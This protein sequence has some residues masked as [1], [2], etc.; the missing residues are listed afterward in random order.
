MKSTFY[1][2]FKHTVPVRVPERPY[3]KL[4]FSEFKKFKSLD[5]VMF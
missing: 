4:N 3:Q 2:D 5:L 1:F